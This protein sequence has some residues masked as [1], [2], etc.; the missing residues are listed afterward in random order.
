MNKTAEIVFFF[1]GLIAVAFSMGL[2]AGSCTITLDSATAVV[3]QYGYFVGNIELLRGYNVGQWIAIGMLL[4]GLTF[5]AGAAE[6]WFIR[7]VYHPLDR[8][9]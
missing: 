3:Q 4:F 2:Y 7:T 1:V 6:S 8:K 5:V 9:E